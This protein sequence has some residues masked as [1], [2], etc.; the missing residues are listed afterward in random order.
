[1]TPEDIAATA[2]LGIIGTG[3]AYVLNYQITPA[4]AQPPHQW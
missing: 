4:T 1:M 3:F 2:V